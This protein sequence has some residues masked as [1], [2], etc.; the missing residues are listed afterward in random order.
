MRKIETQ[1]NKQNKFIRQG[2]RVIV[3]S[4]NDKGKVGTVL[5]R[6]MDRVI[7]QGINMR[8]KAMRPSQEN[9]QGGVIEIERPIHI[10]NIMLCS[11]DDTPRKMK[12]TF[13]DAGNRSL[14]YKDDGKYVTFR[15]IK[16]KTS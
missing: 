11:K 12:V 14:S 5:S 8:K 15:T 16:K 4:G 7:I 9:Q 6:T 10:S 2:D 1:K 3:L 13:D